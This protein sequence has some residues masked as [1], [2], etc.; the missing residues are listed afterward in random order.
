MIICS[1]EQANQL[2]QDDTNL[3]K[4]DERNKDVVDYPI[5]E[6][7][8]GRGAGVENLTPGMRELIA[9]EALVSGK[10]LD[11]IA[12][13]YGISRDAVNAYKHGATSEATYNQPDAKLLDKVNE[14]KTEIKTQAQNKLLLAIQSLTDQKISGA[15]AKDI[16][17]IAKDMSSVLRNVEGPDSNLNFNNS[18][19]LIYSP[20]LKEEDDYKVIEA[21]E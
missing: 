16:A 2:I 20:R 15:K 11:Q 8:R 21:R 4:N 9:E 19:V 14:V 10:T 6:I 5:Q 7:K 1:R 12:D 3:F 17:G 18:K 13:E